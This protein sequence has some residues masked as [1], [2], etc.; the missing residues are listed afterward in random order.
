MLY[1]NKT[2][3]FVLSS[4]L[5]YTAS[6]TS[7]IVKWEH[8]II[9]GKE[10]LYLG[11]VHNI[12]CFAPLEREQLYYFVDQL[13]NYSLSNERPVHIQIEHSGHSHAEE[14]L[15]THLKTILEEKRLK[16][17][18]F[19][20]SEIRGASVCA[21]DI[22]SFITSPDSTD[23]E[24]DPSFISPSAKRATHSQLF[25]VTSVTL[26]DIK[27]EYKLIISELEEKISLLEN[28][29]VKNAALDR[30][31][32]AKGNYSYLEEDLNS[33]H[34]VETEPLVDLVKR[35][36]Q[37]RPTYIK[38]LLRDIFEYSNSFLAV[39]LFV[40]IFTHEAPF[41]VIITGYYHVME[42]NGIASHISLTLREQIAQSAYEDDDSYENEQDMYVVP[43]SE[44]TFFEKRAEKVEQRSFCML[45]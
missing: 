33:F 2:C 5:I 36:L 12:P 16:N 25:Y 39:S 15:I 19:E 11:D 29:P 1:S 45:F 20:N 14:G 40:G 23:E 17:V 34:D 4:L 9:C 42:L 37:I 6:V 26:K 8:D 27:E 13:E 35:E 31:S 43:V 38:S 44:F 41:I 24:R 3:F 22:L 30:F 7:V 32:S 10:V 18:S 21:K 28:G